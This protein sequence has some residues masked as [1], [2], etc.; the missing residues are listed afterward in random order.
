MTKQISDSDKV[1]LFILFFKK[2]DFFLVKFIMPTTFKVFYLCI[3]A[4]NELW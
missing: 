1:A 3:T 2:L 4:C